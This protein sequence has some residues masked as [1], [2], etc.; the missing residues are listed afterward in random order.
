[1]TEQKRSQTWQGEPLYHPADV[2]MLRS[3]ALPAQIFAQMSNA[4]L[5]HGQIETDEARQKAEQA[6]AGV[7]LDLAVR[8]DVRLALVLASPSLLEGLERVEQG[9]EKE[10]RKARVSAGLLRYLIRMSTRPTPFGVFAGVGWGYFAD[11]TELCLGQT[12]LAGLRA[13]PDM[14]WLLKL[15]RHLETDPA[16]VSQ[17][18][19]RLNQTAYLSGE[20]ALLPFADTYGQQ[21]NR[22]ISLRA[23]AVVRKVFELAQEFIV[24]A[25]L[26]TGIQRA[27]PYA[28]PQQVDRV[29]RQLWEHGFLISSLHPPLTDARPGW[30]I[31]NL[32]QT[33]RGVEDV[34]ERFTGI[35]SEATALD[36]AGLGAHVGIVSILAQQQKQLV[37][38]NDEDVPQEDAN[39]LP[40]QVDSAL[41]VKTPLLHRTIGQA[42]AQVATFLLRQTPSPTGPRHLQEYRLLFLDTY[43]EQAEVPLLDLLSPENGLDAPSGYQRPTRTYHRPSMLPPREAGSRDRV[44]LRLLSSALT[45]QC[46]EVELTEEIQ[47]ELE[48]WS[49]RLEEAPLSLE[50]YLQVHAE[51]RSALDRGEWTAVLGSS[52][53]SPSAGRTFGR[54][55]DLLG[56]RGMQA[57]REMVAREEA[58]TPNIIFA[59][60]SYQPWQ[61]RLANVATHPALRT[62]EIAIGVTPAVPPERV[63]TLADLVV[64]VQHGRFYVR[65]LRLGKQVRVCQSHMLNTSL[66]PNACRF[67]MEIANDGLPALSPFDWG[68]LASAPFLPRLMMKAGPQ[69]TLVLSPARWQLQSSTIVPTGEGSAQM[70]WLRGLRDFRA[71]WQVPRYVYLTEMDN[72]LL[73]DLDNPLMAAQLRDALKKLN[74][75]TQLTLEELLPDFEHL[76][77]RDEQERAYFSELVVPML[78]AD[79]YDVADRTPKREQA[80][81]V[82][83]RLI[84]LQERKRFPGEEWVYLK[85]YTSPGQHEELL[86]GPLRELVHV[87][88]EHELLDRWFF[89]RYA[90]P[91]PHLR[92]R[93]HAKEGKHIT[94][95]HSIV[96]PWSAQLAR[97]GQVQRVVLDTYER[98]VERYGGPEA[99]DLLE[100]VFTVDSTS[101]CTLLANQYA[102]RITLDAVLVAV[103]TLDHL[104]TSWGCD[105]HQ[106]L[107][108]TQ[109]VSEKYAFRQEYRPERKR[110]SSLLCAQGPLDTELAA[111][112]ALLLEL[113][114]PQTPY[115]YDLGQQVRQ[116]ADAG[117]LWVSEQSLWGSLAHMHLNRLLGIDRV[118]EN[119]IY[120][121]WRHTL[122]ALERQPEQVHAQMQ[123]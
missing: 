116:L 41:Q 67:L 6:C 88:Q 36:R 122:D 29:L 87:L 68:S 9:E 24:Y 16:V 33:V 105:R 79:A 97:R 48:R 80:F 38:A 81:T 123:E 49:P 76:W 90:D 3:P 39:A 4:G 56:E 54:F 69:A 74:E 19:V 22:A 23:T 12:A 108:W 53:G 119:K 35:L 84:T 91:E 106:C 62:Y 50:I 93:F 102:H 21:D 95:I 37:A 15:L 31:R 63:L 44:L 7:L 10:A 51:S 115:L 55:F 121:F 20:R 13:R 47:H 98:E 65:S 107:T 11:H 40:L 18:A 5:T 111:Q 113:L 73:L 96:L 52:C 104:F 17:L 118:R 94:A 64:G 71:Q 109:N 89:I 114:H 86:A 26:Q 120:A 14:H 30:Y 60:L 75:Q 25:D 78:R 8:P 85:L 101:I 82:P 110:Y 103:F 66:A 27:F 2:Y 92:L 70:R 42:A 34:K 57:L 117:T 1:M 77:L 112:R 59:E 83:Q 58:L 45:G 46:R 32:L 100:Q 99:M 61:A 28:T 43:G 72:R